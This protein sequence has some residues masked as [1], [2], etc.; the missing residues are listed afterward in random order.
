MRCA[1]AQCVARGQS[2]AKPIRHPPF[3]E[4]VRQVLRLI[5]DTFKVV[6]PLSL[7]EWED[8][9]RRDTHPEKEIGIWANMAGAFRHFTEGRDLDADQQ[10]DIFAVILACWNNGPDNVLATVNCRTLSRNRIKAM[11]AGIR[12]RSA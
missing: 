11:V 1:R 5:Q 7:E 6:R 10:R 12:S 2:V 9:F 4:D 8:G 3:S